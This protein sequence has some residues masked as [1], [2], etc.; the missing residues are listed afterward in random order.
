MKT[1]E[2]DGPREPYPAIEVHGT[3]FEMGRQLGEQARDRIER[4]LTDAFGRSSRRIIG[5][6]EVDLIA[7]AERLLP[8]AEAFSPELVEECRGTA[9]GCGRDFR[10]LFA[11]QYLVEYGLLPRPDPAPRPAC[12]TALAVHRAHAQGHA[13]LAWNDDMEL[14]LAHTSV[15]VRAVPDGG[16]PLVGI[17]FSG[18]IGEC[19]ATRALCIACNS[20]P[21]PTAAEG[22]PYLFVQR[23]ALRQ[24]S[25]EDAVRVIR[26]A[27]RTCCMAFTLMSAEGEYAGLETTPAGTR[28]VESGADTYAH[29]NHYH[30]DLKPY[31]GAEP[32]SG[33]WLRQQGLARFLA[34]HH[35]ALTWERLVEAMS[36]HAAGVCRHGRYTTVT[37]MVCDLTARRLALSSGPPCLN[38]FRAFDL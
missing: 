8:G 3:P 21:G 36:S 22:V 14:E 34:R 32:D 26:S 9:R 1:W 28:F 5:G 25:L 7:H 17:C 38:R 29:T 4:L 19:G 20:L 27:R 33:S 24:A 13:L 11:A 35:G 15:M 16:M 30:T 2:Q 23:K 6:A 31:A 37:A 18:M 12:S 10:E